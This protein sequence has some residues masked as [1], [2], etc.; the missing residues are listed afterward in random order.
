MAV[1]VH[2]RISVGR[3]VAEEIEGIFPPE[4]EEDGYDDED[5]DDNAV[6]YELIGDNCLDEE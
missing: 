2:I 5:A 4:A 3:R 1:A 6:T